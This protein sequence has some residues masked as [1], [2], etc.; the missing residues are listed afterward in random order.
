MSIKTKGTNVWFVFPDSNGSEMVLLGCPKGVSGLSGSKSQIDETCLD[1]QEMEFGPGM[2][3]PQA[4]TIN[5]DLDWTKVSHRDLIYMDDNDIVTTFIIG[6]SDG[7][8]APT[9]VANTGVITYPNTRSF[10]SF[11]GYLADVPLDIAINANVTSAVS[12]QRSGAKS[13]HFKV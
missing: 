1:S 5:V 2:A 4:V 7:T 10:V 9:V 11:Q 12:I 13:Y 8:S 3:N 6:F